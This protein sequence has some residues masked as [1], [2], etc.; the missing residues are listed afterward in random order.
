MLEKDWC[1][2]KG[3][4]RNYENAGWRNTCTLWRR[5]RERE[6]L[7]TETK[8][9]ACSRFIDPSCRRYKESKN[10][11]DWHNTTGSSRK[12]RSASRI[13]DWTGNRYIIERP[14]QMVCNL[15]FQNKDN[16][17]VKHTLNPDAEGY[18]TE[19]HCCY[20]DEGRKRCV[21]M[22]TRDIKAAAAL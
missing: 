22:F 5:E 7:S 14:V 8:E 21:I 13:Q 6:D 1:T 2:L 12:R 18:C 20:L 10:M 19:S 17:V 9:N 15:E 4:K 3:A 16:K 11:E